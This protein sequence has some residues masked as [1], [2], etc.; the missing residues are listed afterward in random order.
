MSA[1]YNLFIVFLTNNT[2][3]QIVLFSKKQNKKTKK[4]NIN[5]KTPTKTNSIN[6]I[7]VLISL[8]IVFYLLLEI[9]D[10]NT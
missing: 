10:R 3:F 9:C 6:I 2:Y 1:F 8:F 5:V 4:H 7:V